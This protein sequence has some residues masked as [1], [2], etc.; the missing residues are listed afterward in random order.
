MNHEKSLDARSR[1]DF[2]VCT[3]N[4]RDVIA[5]TLESIAKQTI[6]NFTC[7]LVD[8]ASTDGTLELVREEFPWVNI[9]IKEEN[10][11]PAM[12]RNLGLAQGVAE[13]VIFVD[14]DVRLD[15]QWAEA[16][17][18]FLNAHP[19]V[20][21]V[22]GKLVY[23]H[24]PTKLFST[25]GAMNHYGVAWDGGRGQRADQFNEPIRC[26][27]ANTSALFVRRKAAEDIGGFDSDLFAGYE[28]VDF[29]WR[30]NLFG[31]EVAFN[32]LAVAFHDA[33]G[34]FDPKVMKRELIY[35]V[36]R[37][38]LR[39]VLVNYELSSLLRYTSVYLVLALLDGL[40]Y[41][42]RKEKLGALWW[43]ARNMG[44]N[45]KRRRWIQARRKVKDQALWEMFES[46][47]RG[48]GYDS[49]GKHPRNGKSRVLTLGGA[50]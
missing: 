32:P 41:G 24:E 44:K 42:P 48:P 29:G 19:R 33:H 15:T 31:Y 35:L 18:K 28:D 3:R 16:Q 2:V 5:S 6:R 36:W 17:I 9:V 46:G 14:S 8:G 45:L 40:V 11:G 22:C 27:F 47:Y 43:N 4:N 23:A 12:S 26:L 38:R 34:T 37:H 13:Y 30:A 39:S 49:G 25:Y 7:T 20:A 21:I 1:I 50:T 10:S